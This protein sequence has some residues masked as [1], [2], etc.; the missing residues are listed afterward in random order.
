V[1]KLIRFVTSVNKTVWIDPEKVVCI[2]DEGQYRK[3]WFHGDLTYLEV[4]DELADISKAVNEARENVSSKPRINISIH[5]FV[6]D[7]AK[8]AKDLSKIIREE[9][10]RE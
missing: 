8:L 2:R 3:I 10:E 1:N 4:S 7:E 5:G 9:E 6:G